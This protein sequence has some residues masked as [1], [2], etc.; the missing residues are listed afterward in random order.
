[1]TVGGGFRAVLWVA[2]EEALRT[3]PQATQVAAL[4]DLVLSVMLQGLSLEE[5]CEA[6]GTA[7]E[8]ARRSLDEFKLRLSSILKRV[9]QGLPA[10]EHEEGQADS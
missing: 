4:R 2:I 3:Y 9:L 1:V 7:P 5:Y 6:K 8:T 10:Q